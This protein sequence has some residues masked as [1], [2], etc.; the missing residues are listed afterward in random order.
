MLSHV[1]RSTEIIRFHPFLLFV[2]PPPKTSQCS[3]RGH[4]SFH[5]YGQTNKK[6]FTKGIFAVCIISTS[7][8]RYVLLS[9]GK[10]GKCTVFS[11][12]THSFCSFL[13]GMISLIMLGVVCFYCI[14]NV[15]F[16]NFK[17]PVGCYIEKD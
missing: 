10:R 3:R 1:I 15:P 11:K 9:Q 4:S 12:Q 8:M 5:L 2:L 7:T 6:W 14:N 17:K 16:E 13:I